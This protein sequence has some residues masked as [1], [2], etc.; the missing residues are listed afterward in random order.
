MDDLA[1]RLTA[2]SDRSELARLLEQH[3][4]ERFPA[5][6]VVVYLMQQDG[7]FLAGSRE[8]LLE[9]GGLPDELP[10]REGAEGDGG[11]AGG[12]LASAP[13]RGLLARLEPE[14]SI[15][16]PDRADRW[17]GLIVLG[18]RVDGRSWEPEHATLRSIAS[19]AG[20]ALEI[21][22][23]AEQ[24]AERMHAER[25]ND[26]EIAIARDVQYRLLPQR[27][28]PLRSLE[29]AAHCIQARSVGGDYYDFLDLGEERTALVLADVSGKGMS[30]ALRMA[31]LHAHLRSQ[32]ASAPRDPLRVL[33]QVNRMLCESTEPGHFATLFIGIYDDPTHRM[34]Y[35]NAGHNPPL[36]LRASGPAEWLSATAT[37]LG[38][39]ESWDC[40]LGR[41]QLEPGD[42]LIAYSD[43]LTEAGSGSDLFGEK[44]LEAAAR[45]L[46]GSSAEDVLA[47]LLAR[48]EAFAHGQPAD[49]LTLL[50]ARRRR[51]DGGAARAE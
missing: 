45:E 17:V 39:F 12:A 34:S 21:I 35:I 26:R 24:L 15:P 20:V 16:I 49:D 33:R 23:L 10:V 48:A 40:A 42:V 9:L 3:L 41:T 50:V 18:R 37:V 43:G 28:P 2:A 36:L 13:L 14:G 8:P 22:Q 44:R 1:L 19:H 6:P 31:N 38:S 46:S 7:S 51:R 5:D 11:E 30:A 32:L 4:R 29:L 25:S 47:G 27:L